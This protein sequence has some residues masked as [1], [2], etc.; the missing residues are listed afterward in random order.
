V[1]TFLAASQMALN[2]ASVTLSS[3]TASSTAT[4]RFLNSENFPLIFSHVPPAP[5][6]MISARMLVI[7]SGLGYY[8]SWNGLMMDLLRGVGG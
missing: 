3:F 8:Q 2:S 6:A 7:V 1:K 5:T 4:T